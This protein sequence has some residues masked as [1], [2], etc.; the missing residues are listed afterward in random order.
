[1][2]D[3]EQTE[4]VKG[5]PFG[6]AVV[7]R[8]ADAMEIATT[9]AAQEVQAALVVA[10]RFPRN[11][12][13]AFD[14]IMAACQRPGLAE[15]AAYQFSRGG[16]KIYG[17]SVHLLRAIAKRWGNIDFGWQEIARKQ[18]EST[19]VSYA[20]DMQHNSSRRV[21]FTVKH[22]RDVRGGGYDL[23]DERDI[24]ELCANQAARRE[25][26]CLEG[27]I[28][29]DIVDSALS[30]CEKTLA[31]GHKEPLADRV[32]KMTT[33]FAELNVTAGMMEKRL[34]HK[35]DATSEG[36]LI[37]LRRIYRSLADGMSSVK[38]FFEVAPEPEKPQGMNGKT[39]PAMDEGEGT[40]LGPTRQKTAAEQQPTRETAP[41]A[42]TE[43][44]KRKVKEKPAEA[45]KPADTTPAQEQ[46]PEAAQP[47]RRSHTIDPS[48]M[49]AAQLC[50]ALEEALK[51][52]GVTEG[53][54]LRFLVG[55]NAARPDQTK[56][57]Q[58]ATSKLQ[59]VATQL[60]TICANIRM[61]R[62]A[63]PA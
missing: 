5:N 62:E 41:A 39:K 23:T 32:R 55:K 40:D 46:K 36:E 8:E 33:A 53:E 57:E 44:P 12:A 13:K 35:L 48:G 21:T 63:Q 45:P 61:A 11:E 26:A 50:D 4:V 59:S 22:R 3:N 14:A 60:D 16:T 56:L 28:D 31:T 15:V 54:V 25:R 19:I 9:R 1:M 2:S 42:Q 30:A 18:G 43:Q 20:W 17:P 7:K 51:E 27:V 52:E 38:D 6:Q 49:N 58:L 34:Q 10:Q 47:E 29:E 24:Y 37:G